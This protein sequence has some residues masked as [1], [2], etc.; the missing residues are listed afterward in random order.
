MITNTPRIQKINNLLAKPA[1]EAQLGTSKWPS[2]LHCYECPRVRSN[3]PA[4]P[5]GVSHCKPPVFTVMFEQHQLAGWGFSRLLLFKVIYLFYKSFDQ[6]WHWL[7][8]L[9]NFEVHH[10]Q[11]QQLVT[12]TTSPFMSSTVASPAGLQFHGLGQMLLDAFDWSWQTWLQKVHH[13]RT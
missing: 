13:R 12:S 6:L 9:V 3:H 7:N 10:H 2:L 4:S 5:A 11:A 1:V 8:C